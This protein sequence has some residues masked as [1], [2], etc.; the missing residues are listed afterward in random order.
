MTRAKKWQEHR[1]GK[2]IKWQ[3]HRKDKNIEMART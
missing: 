2:N 3:E 1:N